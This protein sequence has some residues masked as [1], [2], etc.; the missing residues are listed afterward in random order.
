MPNTIP[1]KAR[2][3]LSKKDRE[4]FQVPGSWKPR[5]RPD[6]VDHHPDTAACKR[7][8][9]DERAETV[10]KDWCDLGWVHPPDFWCRL[11]SP[12]GSKPHQEAGEQ[13]HRGHL[14]SP[15]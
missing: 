6:G 9:G 2:K 8:Q 7:R 5:Q 4:D 14:Q 13:D 1:E 15:A 12:V 10:T 3:D 11:E